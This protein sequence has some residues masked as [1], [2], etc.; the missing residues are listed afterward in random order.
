MKHFISILFVITF[1]ILTSCG[2]TLRKTTP[3]AE[4]PAPKIEEGKYLFEIQPS[5]AVG[6]VTDQ[7]EDSYIVKSYDQ[8]SEPDGEVGE[9]VQDVLQRLFE[10][11]GLKVEE[12]SPVEIRGAVKVWLVDVSSGFPASLK[13][14]AVVSLEVLDPAN[15]VVYR[16]T[17]K[18]EATL[19]RMG[20]EI[21][22]LQLAL[23]YAMTEALSQIIKDK[24]L[25]S[26]ISA[27]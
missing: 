24:K 8:T 26:N 7:R 17:Y 11:M 3:L 13:A 10:N 20:V 1:L 18:G 23:N 9:Q 16:G 12:G 25:L 4:I 21:N 15:R 14:K 5:V 6:G 22:D 27:F 2:P 19:Q